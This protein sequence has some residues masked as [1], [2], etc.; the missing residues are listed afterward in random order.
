[1]QSRLLGTPGIFALLGFVVGICV[2]YMLFA[3]GSVF[4]AWWTLHVSR[5]EWVL[6]WERLLGIPLLGRESAPLWAKLG[7]ALA[8]AAVARL[9]SL[10]V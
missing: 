5:R 2:G 8:C 7:A 9:P 3:T 1:L 6:E 10:H 4:G